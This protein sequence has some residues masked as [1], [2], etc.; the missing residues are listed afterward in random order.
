MLKYL[1]IAVTALSMTACVMLIPLWVR[2]YNTGDV[3]MARVS[4]TRGVGI[5][6]NQGR[7]TFSAFDYQTL[8][9]ELPWGHKSY[10]AASFSPVGAAWQLGSQTTPYP[11]FFVVVPVL[12]PLL[13]A[14]L[15]G[16]AAV[17]RQ[18]YRFS[19]RT[20]LI[21]TTVVTLGLGLIIAVR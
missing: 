18:P 5:V 8:S 2:S 14:G 7:L 6:S 10:Q 17:F 1:R 15:I 19:L 9:H 21:A 13:V 20:L 11:A 4:G 12:F 16:V 3:L